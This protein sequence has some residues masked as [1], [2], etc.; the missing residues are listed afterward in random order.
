MN[1]RMVPTKKKNKC[2]KVV[3]DFVPFELVLPGFDSVL[4]SFWMRPRISMRCISE[5]RPE[6]KDR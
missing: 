5:E 2:K 6:K 4:V 1:A 3:S